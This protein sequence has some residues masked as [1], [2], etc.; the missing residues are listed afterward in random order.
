MDELLGAA[1]G[2][3]NIKK[4]MQ[5]MQEMTLEAHNDTLGRNMC[6]S[7]KKCRNVIWRGRHKAHCD[8][9]KK[10]KK[11]L[12]GLNQFELCFFSRSLKSCFLLQEDADHH[13]SQ[14]TRT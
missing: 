1:H 7:V 13:N 11:E 10:K 9:E 14:S 3:N 8:F 6:H 2:N 12:I 4:K 5:V